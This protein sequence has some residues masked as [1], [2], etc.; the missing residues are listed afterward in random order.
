[1]MGLTLCPDM[2]SRTMERQRRK[3]HRRSAMIL[4]PQR[5]IDCYCYWLPTCFGQC[6]DAAEFLF[7]LFLSLLYAGT[8][9]ISLVIQTCTNDAVYKLN[10]RVVPISHR[11]RARRREFKALCYPKQQEGLPGYITPINAMLLARASAS[12]S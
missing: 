10:A 6:R 2:V 1:M 3:G 4:R 9:K 7:C 8:C 5:I 12:F 11:G